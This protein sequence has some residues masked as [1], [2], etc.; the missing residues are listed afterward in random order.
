M[1]CRP[2]VVLMLLALASC[3]PE[4]EEAPPVRPVL[5]IKAE[6]R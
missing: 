4:A 2:L 6:V 3:K 5:S 1:N